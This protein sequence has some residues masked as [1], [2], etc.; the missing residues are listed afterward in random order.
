M[1]HKFHEFVPPFTLYLNIENTQ[2]PAW[3][4]FEKTIYTFSI[5]IRKWLQQVSKTRI[6]QQ[7][8][9]HLSNQVSLT[10]LCSLHQSKHMHICTWTSK[11][12]TVATQSLNI[13]ILTLK[14]SNIPVLTAVSNKQ[15]LKGSNYQARCR[16]PA[17]LGILEH[18]SLLY[19]VDINHYAP[20]NHHA[21]RSDNNQKCRVI[22]TGD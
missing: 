10:I 13:P 17:F 9:K 12:N 3:K 4:H 15:P 2:N 22:S 20:G 19:T 16:N 6:N 11:V 21:R 7:L 5:I 1:T 18:I 14:L 8:H